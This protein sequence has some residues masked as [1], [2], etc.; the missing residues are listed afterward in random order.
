[1]CSV[2]TSPGSP[3]PATRAL[4]RHAVQACAWASGECVASSSPTFS[5]LATVTGHLDMISCA[6]LTDLVLWSCLLMQA[7]CVDS[8]TCYCAWLV[9]Y[10]LCSYLYQWTFLTKVLNWTLPCCNVQLTTEACFHRLWFLWYHDSKAICVCSWIHKFSYVAVLG[11]VVS[12][13]CH[14]F[15]RQWFYETEVLDWILLC[16]KGSVMNLL[17]LNMIPRYY[18]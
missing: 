15:F 7:C 12:L 2:K 3:W 16:C 1:V 17:E 5:S 18:N 4:P 6:K 8:V 13:L 14:H 11:Q 10:M 9:I